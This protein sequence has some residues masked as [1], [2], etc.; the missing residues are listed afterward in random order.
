M[1]SNALT[2]LERR[3]ENEVVFR[4]VNETIEAATDVGA[5]TAT[6][7]C[8]CS[9][10]NCR[11]TLELPIAEYEQVRLHAARFIVR[12]EHEVTDEV[13]RVVERRLDYS[14][15]EKTGYAAALA[16]ASYPRDRNSLAH[17]SAQG[18]ADEAG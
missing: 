12:P 11:Q 2:E 14:V 7:L 13:G 16:R 6:F 3:V 15:I 10:A 18:R 5:L 17:A 1:A 9:D 4:R 8:E